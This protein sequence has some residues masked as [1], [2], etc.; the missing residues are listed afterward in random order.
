[1]SEVIPSSVTRLIQ[2]VG[3]LLLWFVHRI[4]KKKRNWNSHSKELSSRKFK[5]RYSK[6]LSSKSLELECFSTVYNF[7]I[8]CF[9]AA[10]VMFR[11]L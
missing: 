5:L 6:E 8:Q 1:M 4:N 10:P 11:I 7:I 9:M 3:D 2:K